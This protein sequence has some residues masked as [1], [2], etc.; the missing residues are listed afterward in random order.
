MTKK[1]RRKSR[2]EVVTLKE[3]MYIYEMVKTLPEKTGK[4][5]F[6]FDSG[7]KG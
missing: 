5:Y 2:G 1:R 3:T 4:V 6:A 7:I